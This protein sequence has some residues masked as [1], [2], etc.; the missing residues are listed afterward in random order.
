MMTLITG[1]EGSIE[2]SLQFVLQLF[3]VFNR[4]DRQPTLLQVL[5]LATSLLSIMNAKVDIMFAD[6]PETPFM[7]KAKFWPY[8]LFFSIFSWV[9]MSL[10]ISTIQWNYIWFFALALALPLTLLALVLALVVLMVLCGL[11]CS[12]LICLGVC[13]RDKE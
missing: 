12:P 5:T 4:A 2:G 1:I 11:I 13:L 3:I 6:K 10:I 7:E 8:A 9:S